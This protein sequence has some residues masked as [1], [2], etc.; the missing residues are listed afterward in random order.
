VQDFGRAQSGDVFQ[1][2]VTC[3]VGMQVVGG[4]SVAEIIPPDED[5][6]KKIHQLFSGPL[7]A[8]DWITTSTAVSTI[9]QNHNLRYT[10]SATCAGVTP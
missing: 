5:D 3:P 2:V 9:G 4:G 6:L 8:I 10:A 1:V 7:S